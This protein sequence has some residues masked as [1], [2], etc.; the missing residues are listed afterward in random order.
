MEDFLKFIF[1]GIWI[2]FFYVVPFLRRLLRKDNEFEEDLSI[3]S[4]PNEL[5]YQ[6]AEPDA[7]P[8]SLE[9]VDVLEQQGREL[10][11]GL[12][13]LPPHS[14]I[15]ADVVD[16]QLLVDLREG[17]NALQEGLLEEGTEIIRVVEFRF[18]VLRGL[19]AVRLV[20]GFG[21][22]LADA[23]T[24]SETLFKPF[25]QL[26]QTEAF[27]FARHQPICVPAAPDEESIWFGLLPEGYPIIF[28]PRDFGQNLYRWASLP[29]EIGHLIFRNVPGF[30][31]ELRKRLGLN[32]THMCIR[33]NDEEGIDLRQPFAAWLEEI[34][35]DAFAVLLMGPAALRG[36]TGCFASPSNPDNVLWAGTLGGF[37]YAPHPPSHLR[38]LFA[39]ELLNLM[40]YDVEAAQLIE[41]WTR[42]HNSPDVVYLP[43]LPGGALAAPVDVMLE[44]GSKIIESF[45]YGAY[46]SMAEREL[47]SIHGLELT[48][49]LWAH[50]KGLI[51]T[52][53]SGQA[54]KADPK[55]VLVGAIEAYAQS[56]SSRDAIKAAVSASIL[57]RG[58]QERRPKDRNYAKKKT[59]KESDFAND[60]KAA[61]V[62]HELLERRSI[63]G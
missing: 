61:I 8:V 14:W 51:T 22:H 39:G 10:S 2:F 49:G 55:L 47:R 18:L 42:Q 9:R 63:S 62:L 13:K 31:A 56:P 3:E 1:V 27:Y 26:S 43:A 36:L 40:G 25:S 24:L 12:R 37:Q 53:Q 34:V 20:D 58:A 28:V 48:P 45:Y 59:A 5:G 50:A 29:H 23:E 52:L 6:Q 46:S 35:A 41:D 33:I 54:V 17:R 16:N 44:I 32:G 11:I 60:V 15:L 4:E 19:A 57:G 7:P 30:E 38:I 21:A